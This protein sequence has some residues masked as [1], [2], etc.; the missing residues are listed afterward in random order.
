[1]ILIT[2]AT[3]LVGSQICREL[4]RNSHPFKALRRT[5]SEIPDDLV[6][7]E[8]VEGDILDYE[9]IVESLEGV[10]TVIHAAAV[11]S[12]FKGDYKLMED[13]N[14]DGT[15]NV[16]NAS[17]ETS[18]KK[19]IHISSVAALGRPV[20]SHHIDENIQWMESSNN[21]YYGETKYLAELEVWR[22]MEEGI[23]VA[24]VNP[25]VVL[26][27]GDWKNGSTR[28]FKYAW[29]EHRYF[30]G[31]SF[32]YIDNRDVATLVHQLVPSDY[33]GERFILNAGSITYESFFKLVSEKFN[34]KAPS[35]K[36]SEKLYFLAILLESIKAFLTRTK[37]IIT[38]ESLISTKKEYHFDASKI[39]KL[40]NFAFKDLDDTVGWV[41]AGLQK[42]L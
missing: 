11:I 5:S 17:L 26:G 23:Q 4:K 14:V 24:I 22:A 36:V 40:L 39:K 12:F 41:A 32:N 33:V 30:P 42:E 13:T 31:G 21:S 27:I 9:S 35:K 1:M 19:I 34:K 28:L 18:V 20:S 7:I 6:D 8:W 2:G 29:D 16:V 38:K 15:R 10:S 3:G 25:S 37:P